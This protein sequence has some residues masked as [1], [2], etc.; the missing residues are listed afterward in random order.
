MATY[1]RPKESILKQVSYI[2]YVHL[3]TVYLCL[4]AFGTLGDAYKKYG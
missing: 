4:I 2:L 1:K 3:K